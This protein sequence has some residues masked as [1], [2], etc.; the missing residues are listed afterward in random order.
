MLKNLEMI[1]L[2][3]KSAGFLLVKMSEMNMVVEKG[4]GL[5]AP[6]GSDIPMVESF[7]TSTISPES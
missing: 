6:A 2:R 3:V 5:K 7:Q 1:F 4:E